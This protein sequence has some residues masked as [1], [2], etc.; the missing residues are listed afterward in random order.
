[1]QSGEST[2]TDFTYSIAPRIHFSPDTMAYGR[3]ASGYRPGGPNALP[4]GVTNVPTEYKS[5]STVNYEIGMRSAAWDKRLSVDV[6]AFLVNW[7]DIQLLEVVN[8]FGVNANGGTA[9][10]EGVE[11]TFGLAPV[12]G[13]SLTLTGAYTDSYLTD[14]A[15]AAGGVEGDR[16]P[17]VPKWSGSLGATYTWHAFSDYNMFAGGSWDY[18]GARWTDFSS[19]DG[20]TPNPRVEMGGYDTVNLQLGLDSTHWQFLLWA[21]NIADSR[22]MTNYGSTGTP[23][24]GGSVVWQQ[25]RT[26]G[27]TVTARF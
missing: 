18:I 4:P 20:V 19:I 26:L 25:P 11:W 15:P 3:I 10:S 23:N 21:K 12:T 5:D 1:V 14:N 7:K 17:N 16:L 13:L 6:A 2:G 27:V 22:G 24:L 9:R 8:G